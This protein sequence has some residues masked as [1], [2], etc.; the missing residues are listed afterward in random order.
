[1]NARARTMITIV[2][3]ENLSIH[4]DKFTVK[5]D[6]SGEIVP[7]TDVTFVYANIEEVY[8]R[9]IGSSTTVWFAAQLRGE[10]RN[11][12]K[13]RRDVIG[14]KHA[15]EQACGTTVNVAPVGTRTSSGTTVQVS[16]EN[17]NNATSLRE[18][19]PGITS[20]DMCEYHEAFP[21]DKPGLLARFAKK[22][23]GRSK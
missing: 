7:I 15:C 5:L 2:N 9:T 1:M 12:L 18:T 17:R 8:K 13:G 21:E 4:V 22:Y 20:D 10:F 16:K 19:Y 3:H 14:F 11:K 6:K 23:L